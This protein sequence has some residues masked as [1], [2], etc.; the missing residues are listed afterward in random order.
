MNN[1]MQ[2]L[3]Y[4]N[5]ILIEEDQKS[6]T[7]LREFLQFQKVPKDRYVSVFSI[8]S[9]TSLFFLYAKNVFLIV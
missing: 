7:K 5:L 4:I 6:T 9:I 1:K 8:P 2:I 3:H